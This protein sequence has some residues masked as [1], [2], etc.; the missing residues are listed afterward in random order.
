MAK[1]QVSAGDARPVG[2]LVPEP[3]VELIPTPPT[4]VERGKWSQGALGPG[5]IV[6]MCAY[7]PLLMIAFSNGRV[8]QGHLGRD[9]KWWW[10]ETDFTNV[11]THVTPR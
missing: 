7:G 9:D 10:T 5:A 6:A 2:R 1:R 11:G 4:P 8:I 3:D